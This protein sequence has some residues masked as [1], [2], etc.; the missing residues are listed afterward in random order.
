MQPDGS[1]LC[2][3][4]HENGK[5]SICDEAAALDVSFKIIFIFNIK[6]FVNIP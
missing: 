4:S 5:E 2:F 1:F 6:L 3:G